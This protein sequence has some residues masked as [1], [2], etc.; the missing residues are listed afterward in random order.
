[1]SDQQSFDEDYF[2][3]PNMFEPTHSSQNIK[4]NWERFLYICNR[5]SIWFANDFVPGNDKSPAPS[6]TEGSKISTANCWLVIVSA[7]IVYNS[8]QIYQI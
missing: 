2:K 3:L 1:M 7:M 8:Y 4:D 6:N 5:T